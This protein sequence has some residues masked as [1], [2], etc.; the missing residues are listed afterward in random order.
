MTH[1]SKQLHFATARASHLGVIAR[2]LRH[3][4]Q[5]LDPIAARVLHRALSR[6]RRERA[7]AALHGPEEHA[8][9]ERLIAAGM[10]EEK[11]GALRPSARTEATFR[12]LPSPERFADTP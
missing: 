4:R 1:Q 8:A 9:A 5:P 10:L 12:R 6:P 3:H 11:A 2:C 7:R